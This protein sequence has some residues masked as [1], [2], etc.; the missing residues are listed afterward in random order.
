MKLKNGKLF[1]MQFSTA[2]N[3]IMDIKELK[4]KDKLNLIRLRK[5]MSDNA[6][7][8]RQAIEE[9]S[10]DE[11][12]TLMTDESE[13]KFEPISDNILYEKLSATSI[14]ELEGILSESNINRSIFIIPDLHCPFDHRDAL[15][16]LIEV[17]NYFKLNSN[18]L[19]VFLGDEIDGNSWSY[20][21]TS[22]DADYTPKQELNKAIKHLQKYM[23]MFPHATILESNHGSLVYRKGKTAMLPSE[24]FKSYNQILD[25]PDTWKWVYELDVP[26]PNG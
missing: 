15:P 24:V 9:K 1:S 25:A 5:K 12:N 19:V 18:T 10:D 16:F 7:F 20:H 14:L 11:I 26:L 23:L 4:V 22:P 8:M 13:Y 2:I 3:D 6:I 17:W 21:P